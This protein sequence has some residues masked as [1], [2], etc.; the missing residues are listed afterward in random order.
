[1]ATMLRH[2]FHNQSL[3]GA[4]QSQILKPSSCKAWQCLAALKMSRL[5]SVITMTKRTIIPG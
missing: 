4:L 2:A 3:V 1:M 5:M